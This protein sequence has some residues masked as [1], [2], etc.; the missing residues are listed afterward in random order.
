MW[1]VN[2]KNKKRE[3]QFVCQGIELG[4]RMH[5]WNRNQDIKVKSP[6]IR[7]YQLHLKPYSLPLLYVLNGVDFL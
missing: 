5:E 1:F 6:E 3:N 4:K 2:R 7:G